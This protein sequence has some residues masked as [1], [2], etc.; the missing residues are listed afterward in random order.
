MRLPLPSLLLVVAGCGVDVGVTKSSICDGQAQPS[1]DTVDAPYD[2][3]QDGYFD[4]S[5]A[6]C[7]AA[8]AADRLDCDDR[9]PAVHPGAVEVG[10]DG[11]DNDCDAAT[12]DAVDGDGD[13]IDACLDCDDADDRVRPGNAEVAC[14]Q[15]DDDCDE[16]T[17]DGADDDLDL[18]TECFDC[19]DLNPAVNPGTAEVL[20]NL[21][22]DDCNAA[23][24]DE[25]DADADGASSCTDC[26]DFDAQRFPSNEEVCDD[27]I[28][29]NCADGIDEDCVVDYTG[30]WTLDQ[31]IRYSCAFS[32]VSINFSSV[33]VQDT[34]PTI[35]VVS[36]GS[37]SQPGTMT[38]SFTGAADFTASRTISGSC[39]EVYTFDGSFTSD[40]T[41]EGTFT[42][43]FIGA[44]FDC[45][46][47]SWTVSGTR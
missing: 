36:G 13:G 23:T 31:T 47:Q 1:E 12:P 20:C 8:Y 35:T 45:S 43:D 25:V 4:G 22:D 16:A 15:L 14:N 37:G 3:D 46:R 30:T 24:P 41:F 2:V 6:D 19:D 40:T 27:G 11:V 26:D 33:F 5:N 39:D 7:V 9:D 21:V 42:A 17:P 32:L 29:N 38:G 18:Y 44:C 28:D 10:C 34:N